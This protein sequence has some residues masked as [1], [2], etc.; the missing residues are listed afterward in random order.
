MNEEPEEIIVSRGGICCLASVGLFLLSL[1]LACGSGHGPGPAATTHRSVALRVGV[2]LPSGS[3]SG[4]VPQLASNQTFEALVRI[5]PDG[6]PQAWLAKDWKL[7]AD[8]RSVVLNLRPDAKFQDGS[9]VDASTVVQAVRDA[10]PG[11]L[12]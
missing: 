5:G 7:A 6:R 4:G 3:P 9:F 12:G 2:N 10:L 11:F 8:R 1:T